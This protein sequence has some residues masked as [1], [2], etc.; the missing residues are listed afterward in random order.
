MR[1]NV[2]LDCYFMESVYHQSVLMLKL[3][4]PNSWLIVGGNGQVS[5]SVEVSMG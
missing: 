3:I 4:S 2:G 1:A 5:V